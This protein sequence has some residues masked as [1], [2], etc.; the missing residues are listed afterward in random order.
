MIKYQVPLVFGYSWRL[1][2]PIGRKY[3]GYFEMEKVFIKSFIEDHENKVLNNKKMIECVVNNGKRGGGDH[4]KR[5][6]ISCWKK[7]PWTYKSDSI[8]RNINT[9]RKLLIGYKHGK[10]FVLPCQLF[11]YNCIGTRIYLVPNTAIRSRF[12]EQKRDSHYLNAQIMTLTNIR[13]FRCW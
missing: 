4:G 11:F 13:I 12:R 3:C 7:Y 10:L 6:V 2:S 9:F 1:L 8:C 5:K